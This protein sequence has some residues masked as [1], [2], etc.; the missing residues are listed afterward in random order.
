MTDRRKERAI[1]P[2]AKR[3]KEEGSEIGIAE[4]PS[5]TYD[6]KEEHRPEDW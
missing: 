4:R 3:G 1:V 6:D 5:F 2:L